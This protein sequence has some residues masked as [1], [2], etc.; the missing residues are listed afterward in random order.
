MTCEEIRTVLSAYLDSE[1]ET[2]KSLEVTSHLEACPPCRDRVCAETRLERGIREKLGCEPVCDKFWSRLEGSLGRAPWRARVVR[3]GTF[4]ASVAA[5][6]ALTATILG[7]YPRT[8]GAEDLAGAA[9][10]EVS[11]VVPVGNFEPAPGRECHRCPIEMWKSAAS[12]VGRPV[13]GPRPDEVAPQHRLEAVGIVSAHLGSR[14]VPVAVYRCC[15][16]RVCVF[17]FSLAVLDEF[18]GARSCLVGAGDAVT[19]VGG[20]GGTVALRRLRDVVLVAVGRHDPEG[21][22]RA[23]R[24]E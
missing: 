23:F 12:R 22:V 14:E 17:V 19:H 16:E 7:T 10:R 2:A 24:D 3:V 4:V 8:A 20:G 1:L 18:P 6:V 15:G 5:A 9:L 21:L 11:E 13:R